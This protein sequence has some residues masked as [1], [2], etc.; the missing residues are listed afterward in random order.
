MHIRRRPASSR[1]ATSSTT[2]CATP[3][4]DITIAIPIAARTSIGLRPKRSARRPHSG[5]VTAVPRNVAPNAM[6]DHWITADCA[7]TP[8][9]LTYSG[10]NGSSMLRL[11]SVVNDPNTQTARLRR[12]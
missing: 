2:L 1:S 5:A 6:P 9:C 3:I 8:S 4:S 10:R 7:S 12:Q 11:T